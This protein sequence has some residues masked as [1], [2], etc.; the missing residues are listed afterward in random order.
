MNAAKFVRYSYLVTDQQT[1]LDELKPFAGFSSG[2]TNRSSRKDR[3]GD[4]SRSRNSGF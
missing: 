4:F 2:T 3:H 1:C